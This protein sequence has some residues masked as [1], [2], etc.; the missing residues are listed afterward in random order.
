VASER[1]LNLIGERQ[2]VG[3]PTGPARRRVLYF[4]RIRGLALPSLLQPSLHRGPAVPR[5][6]RGEE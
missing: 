4:G 2:A 1:L 3:S 6:E 5:S